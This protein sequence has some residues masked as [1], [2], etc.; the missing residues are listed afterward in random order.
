MKI[1][2][3]T[4]LNK[5]ILY[6]A[7]NSGTQTTETLQ[8]INNMPVDYSKISFGAIHGVKQKK[9]NVPE[10]KAK[11]LR[12]LNEI[13]EAD[14]PEV[15]PEEMLLIE[16]SRNINW[17][18]SKEKKLEQLLMKMQLLA[19]D[20]YLSPKQ[21]LDMAYA[22]KKEHSSILNSKMAPKKVYIKTKQD[23]K[24]DFA[25]L[26]KFK[27]AVEED[28][29][30]LGKIYTEHYK[31]LATIDTIDELQAKYPHIKIPKRPEVYVAEKVE[32]TFTRD[33]YEKLDD[34]MKPGKEEQVTQYLSEIIMPILEDVA[35]SNKVDK[36]IFLIKT[37]LPTSHLV[38]ERFK[39]IKINDKF[40]SIPENR[41]NK[42]P[43]ITEIE[44]KV[45][46]VNFDKLVLHVARQQYLE[47]QKLNNIVYKENGKE[48]KVGLLKKFDK[49]SE[50][51]KQFITSAKSIIA[52][53]R[54]YELFNVDELKSR[55]AMYSNTQIVNNEKLYNTIFFFYNCNFTNDDIEPLIRFLRELDNIAD[56]KKT[57]E[58]VVEIVEKENLCP[59]GT[60]QLNKQEKLRIEKEAQEEQ[61]KAIELN[62]LKQRFNDAINILYLNNLNKIALL[63]SKYRPQD[64]SET[65]KE[66]IEFLIKLIN[67]HTDSNNG[68]ISNKAKIE[69][70]IVRHDTFNM[71]QNTEPNSEI[72][73][74]S[75]AFAGDNNGNVDKNL[76]GQYIL[77]AEIVANY[78]D[79]ADF[80]RNPDLLHKIM[81]RTNDKKVII[82]ALCKLD[83]F[84]ELTK[85]EKTYIN[86]F[87]GMFDIKDSVEKVILKD[88]I[89]NV[90]IHNN[91]KIATIPKDKKNNIIMS[92][93]NAK[94]KQAIYDKY[95]FPLCLEY[96]EGFEDAMSTT[97]PERGGSGVKLTGRNNHNII[98]KMEVKLIGHDDRLF[99]SNNDYDFDIYDDKGL[100]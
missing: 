22:L 27:S 52:G 98:H 4:S 76:A 20:K 85:E 24:T 86:N 35:N 32:G 5:N 100:H 6:S 46:N 62:T 40:S 80:V 96:L 90:Y 38:L 18:K 97:A 79:S 26:N 72:F 69:A 94:A 31:D 11:L 13:L 68:K 43:Q 17:M 56:N 48:I 49:V 39:D 65:T 78:P 44:A 84:Y 45:V 77:N 2:G 41:K 60:E 93:F 34:L 3:P 91:T 33:F 71:Y 89:E 15:D 64:L 59:R 83:N 74:A 9:I 16:M 28:D 88:I 73:K 66:N 87:L 63:C 67:Q 7:N 14:A 25:L 8:N 10:E 51:P 47:G 61:R 99:S 21:K 70:E 29:F 82:E 19:E 1:T 75:L 53:Q 54:A 81:E 36:D 95:K 42:K 55:L 30:E 37:F 23:E 12:Q 92:T 50:R 58:E 57:C